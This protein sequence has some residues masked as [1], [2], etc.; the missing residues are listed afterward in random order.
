MSESLLSE[1]RAEHLDDINWT[2]DRI[3][4]TF[5][6]ALQFETL[7][8]VPCEKVFTGYCNFSYVRMTYGN[9]N[10]FIKPDDSV[11]YISHTDDSYYDYTDPHFQTL[12]EAATWIKDQ[13]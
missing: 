1:A 6:R 2:V 10:V 12:E 8:G 11:V 5:D 3:N 4:A 7:M 9:S 13:T